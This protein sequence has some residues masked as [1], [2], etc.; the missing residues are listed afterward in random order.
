MTTLQVLE[1]VV[2]LLCELPSRFSRDDDQGVPQSNEVEE[3]AID[4]IEELIK[5]T[6]EL[7]DYLGGIS[8]DA[9]PGQWFIWDGTKYVPKEAEDDSKSAAT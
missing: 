8:A 7:I 3:G 2:S 1:T 9:I 4:R 5:K 6:N